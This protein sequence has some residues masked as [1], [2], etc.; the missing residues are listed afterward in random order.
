MR[1]GKHTKNGNGRAVKSRREHLAPPPSET[2]RLPILKTYKIFIGGKFP[3]TESGR[4]YVLKNPRSQT[5]LANMCLCSR[6]D[7]REAVVAARAAQSSWAARAAFNRS[8]ILYRIA[9]MLEGRTP[10]FI[11]EMIEQGYTESAARLETA[12]SI[13]RLVYYA[14]WT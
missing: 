5:P 14:G 13:D 3:R 6:K 9:E 4:F 11:A 1:N 8:Q 10:Q 7:F 2:S 12:A